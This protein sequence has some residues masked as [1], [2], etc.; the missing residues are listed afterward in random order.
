MIMRRLTEVMVIAVLVNPCAWG[1]APPAEKT[2]W[3]VS[4]VTVLSDLAAGDVDYDGRLEVVAK[5]SNGDLYAWESDGTAMTGWPQAPG[6]SYWAPSMA[7]LDGDGT[8]EI[9]TIVEGAGAGDF[10]RCYRYDGAILWTV[11]P[12]C[13]FRSFRTSAIADVDLDGTLDVFSIAADNGDQW[14]MAY[15]MKG[16]TGADFTDWPINLTGYGREPFILVD[17]D[18]DGDLEVVLPPDGSVVTDALRAY[19][20]SGSPVA[21]YPITTSDFSHGTMGDIEG[22]GSLDFLARAGSVGGWDKFANA[23]PGWPQAPCGGLN[24]IPSVCDVGNGGLLEMAFAT[25][26]TCPGIKG[27]SY[28]YNY[29]GT[30]PLGWPVDNGN[31]SSGDQTLIG[32]T[33]GDE[34]LNFINGMT[35]G[36]FS[37]DSKIVNRNENGAMAAGFPWDFSFLTAGFGGP[38]GILV[39]LDLDGV[40][41]LG[42]VSAEEYQLHFWSLGAS[43]NPLNMHWRMAGGN[44]QHTGEWHPPSYYVPAVASV[45]PALT[46]VTSCPV[47]TLQC[48]GA[49]FESKPFVWFV[50]STDAPDFYGGDLSKG[51]PAVAVAQPQIH[52]VTALPQNPLNATYIEITPPVLGIGSYELVIQNPTGIRNMVKPV[53]T[54]TDDVGASAAPVGDTLMVNFGPSDGEL[55]FDWGDVGNTEYVVIY[56]TAPDGLF[57]SEA[58]QT[59]TNSLT[60]ESPA[61]TMLFFKVGGVNSCGLGP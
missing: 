59:T 55:S 60:V 25:L 30:P 51:I 13:C 35:E 18:G 47:G 19:H 48:S 27:F 61:G 58:G 57:D 54:V 28:L 15:L 6:E 52:P 9:L 11:Q 20:H 46:W 56:D 40:L 8:L 50:P 7:D 4:L 14:D 33:D 34:L 44:M 3:P 23:L 45:S 38:T 2:G 49:S 1:A 12:P 36:S 32:D 16:T 22:N 26:N 24:P 43:Y 5:G 10:L 29:E 39:D 31:F 41:D 42:M 17:I 53:I 37:P 21:G